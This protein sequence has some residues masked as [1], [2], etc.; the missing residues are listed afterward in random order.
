MRA[1]LKKDFYTLKESKLLILILVFLVVV[2]DLWGGMGGSNFV[3]LY[4]S[5]FSAVLV[6]NT[7][8]YDEM[9]NGY[10]FLLAM[11]FSRKQYVLEKYI[12]GL[13]TGLAGLLFSIASGLIM[14]PLSFENTQ[15]VSG[16][17]VG[18]GKWWSLYFMTICIFLFMQ[19]LMIPIQLKFGGQKGRSAMIILFAVLFGFGA[20]F[21]K[22]GATEDLWDRIN[23]FT[24]GQ[25]CGTGLAVALL[26]LVLSYCCS[27]RIMEK[28][29]F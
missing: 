11:P 23:R 15:E 17:A 14:V 16:F 20:A 26:C 24:L 4:V 27:I 25:I 3:L 2:M 29:E 10:A 18:N 5:W 1:L 13:L 6:L 7:I 9:D 21:V 12:F 8:S 19:A 28:K 22:S